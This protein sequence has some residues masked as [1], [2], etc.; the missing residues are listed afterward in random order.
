[1]NTF[2]LVGVAV[3]IVAALGV[4][5][6]LR[7]RRR[8][9]PCA[10]C[11]GQS[12]FGYSTHAESAMKDITPLCFNCLKI[13]LAEDYANF[14]GRALVIQP[15]ADF[16]CYVFQPNGKWKD[17]K[18]VEETGTFLSKMEKTCRHCRASA[19]FLWLTS[20]GLVENSAGKVFGAG[21]SETLLRWG[22]DLPCSVCSRLC[23]A[24]L[25]KHG[26]PEPQ[27]HRSVRPAFGRWLR[28][29]NGVLRINLCGNGQG[30]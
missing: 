3:S 22:N 14:G 27:V 13:K 2:W 5:A 15:A 23:R 9:R 11:G 28:C 30:A 10:N 29:A 24:Y 17:S 1:M 12:L 7:R 4:I 25:Q 21:I 18:L 8:S 16:P 20:N 26:E 6:F 19:Q